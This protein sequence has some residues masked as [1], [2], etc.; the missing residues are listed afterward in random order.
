MTQSNDNKNLAA[1]KNEQ[2]RKGVSSQ[3]NTEGA[4][5]SAIEEQDLALN[6][7][8]DSSSHSSRHHA[9]LSNILSKQQLGSQSSLASAGCLG[10][11]AASLHSQ[12]NAQIIHIDDRL[13]RNSMP[14]GDLVHSN[15]AP[16]SSAIASGGQTHFSNAVDESL[17]RSFSESKPVH[18]A[19]VTIGAGFGCQTSPSI[20]IAGNIKQSLSASKPVK[21]KRPLSAYNVFFQEERARIIGERTNSVNDSSPKTQKQRYQP[22]GTGF[23]DLAKEISKRWKDVG[24]E[25]LQECAQRANADTIRYQSELA[26]YNEQKEEKLSALQRAQ[27]ATV[28]EETWEQYLAAADHQK[29]PRTKKR[30]GS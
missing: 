28:S 3:A 11:S 5:N 24:K 30:K 18:V 7:T 22:N 29:P 21:P 12:Q 15:T 23:E 14:S 25:R 20:T 26:T 16:I 17:L 4:V 9:I 13:R 8:I 1:S 6:R 19:S 27:E 2:Q 10:G